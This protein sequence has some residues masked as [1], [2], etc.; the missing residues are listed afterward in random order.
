MDAPKATTP[1]CPRNAVSVKLMMV[2]AI[3]PNIMGSAMLHISLLVIC[4]FISAPKI[5]KISMGS[6]HQ[7]PTVNCRNSIPHKKTPCTSTD[8]GSFYHFPDNSS[9]RKLTLSSSHRGNSSELDCARS[10]AGRIHYLLNAVA[11]ST[12]TATVAPTIGLLP[13]PRKPIIST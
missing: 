3:F 8:T 1:R 12:A 6:L 5:Q 13:M 9:G 7:L 10:P 4:A 2:W 11:T